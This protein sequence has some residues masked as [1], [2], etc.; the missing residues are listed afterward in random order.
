MRDWKLL[1]TPKAPGLQ[2]LKLGFS[3]GSLTPKVV[4]EGRDGEAA[5]LTHCVSNGTALPNPTH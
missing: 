5:Q 3:P 4:P 1:T 2:Q